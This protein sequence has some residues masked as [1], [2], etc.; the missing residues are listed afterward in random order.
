MYSFVLFA[1]ETISLK[2]H[3][4]CFM[5]YYDRKIQFEYTTNI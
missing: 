3:E 5:F 1:S 2:T 4:T